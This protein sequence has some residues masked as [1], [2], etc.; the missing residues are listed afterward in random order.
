MAFQLSGNYLTIAD[1]TSRNSGTVPAG[2]IWISLA[3]TNRGF[4]YNPGD[5]AT[6]AVKVLLAATRTHR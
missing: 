2:E 3:D 1:A 6:G 4:R 5:S